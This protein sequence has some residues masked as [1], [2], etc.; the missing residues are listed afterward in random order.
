MV[1]FLVLYDTPEDP[2][3]F[4]KHYNVAPVR[5]GRQRTAADVPT[6]APTGVTSVVYEVA[7]V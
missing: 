4:D 3:V 7:E 2:A 1:R 5:G 6:F